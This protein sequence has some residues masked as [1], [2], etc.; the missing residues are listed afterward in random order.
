MPVNFY[1][2]T[3]KKKI[4]LSFIL[5]V[6]NLIIIDIG[7]YFFAK[8]KSSKT[9][10]IN[11]KFSKIRHFKLNN[12]NKKEIVFIGS[13]RTFYQIATNTFKEH[14]LDI[15]NFGVSGIQFY[16]YPTLIPH[17]NK[18]HPKEVIISLQVSILFEKLEVAEYP[19]FEE[20]RYYYDIDKIKF[21]QAIKQWI[22]NRHL[23]LQHSETIFYKIKSTYSKFEPHHKEPFNKEQGTHTPV[24]YSKLANCMVYDLKERGE[25]HKILKCTNGDGVLIGSHVDISTVEHKNLKVLN[26][27]TIKYF[28]KL[29]ENID[30]NQTK[31]SIVLEPIF[32]NAYSYDFNEIQKQF[33]NIRIIDLTSFNVPD[34]YW[35]DNAHLNY[36]G[37]AEYSQYLSTYLTSMQKRHQ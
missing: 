32:H 25:N 4:L 5:I 34:S 15:Y 24:D 35:S 8:A 10:F 36:K 18:A 2:L 23:F 37:R 13:S 31:V 26:K 19:T 33:K 3:F 27:Q 22:T 7:L 20:I 28:Q 12:P 30:Q 1:T 21:L 11:D 16:G 17:I 6:V 14:G 29:V 9:T